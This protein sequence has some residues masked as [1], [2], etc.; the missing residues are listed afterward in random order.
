MR[1]PFARS[2]VLLWHTRV[3][4]LAIEP[5]LQY[6]TTNICLLRSTLRHR[7]NSDENAL[8]KRTKRVL[9]GVQVRQMLLEDAPVHGLVQVRIALRRVHHAVRAAA[10]LRVRRSC[11]AHVLDVA[12]AST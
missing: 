2:S 4:A 10:R 12:S 6:R 11:H 9:P 3:F 1:M 5:M 7:R 8:T